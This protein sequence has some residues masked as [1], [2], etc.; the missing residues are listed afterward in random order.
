MVEVEQPRNLSLRKMQSYDC[1]LRDPS[2]A[3]MYQSAVPDPIA[4]VEYKE[5]LTNLMDFKVIPHSLQAWYCSGYLQ[6]DVKLEIQKMNQKMNRMEEMMT[7]ILKRLS[8]DS[9]SS[10]QSP[11]DSTETMKKSSPLERPT[12]LLG[13][14]AGTSTEGTGIGTVILKKRRSKTRMKTS[15]PQAPSASTK[16]STPDSSSP[17]ESTK[18]LHQDPVTTPSSRK[19]KEFL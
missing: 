2:T 8:P 18:M 12:D 3:S 5:L 4:P 17:T 1:G 9:G 15:A 16:T 13:A 6:V 10:S 14:K 11:S 7:E 19:S